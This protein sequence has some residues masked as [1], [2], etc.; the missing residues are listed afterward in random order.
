[1]PELFLFSYYAKLNKNDLKIKKK[2]LSLNELG[3]Q[4]LFAHTVLSVSILQY[5][6]NSDL[7]SLTLQLI[8]GSD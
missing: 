3:E 6:Q 8:G 1:M 5:G 4:F 2:L 7:K